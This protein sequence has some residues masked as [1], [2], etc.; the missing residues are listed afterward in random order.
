ML[1]HSFNDQFPG[2]PG[3]VIPE[4]QT[5]RIKLQ[6]EMMEVQ[7]WQPTD[8][9]GSTAPISSQII[10]TGISTLSFLQARCLLLPKQQRQS[11]EGDAKKNAMKLKIN[12]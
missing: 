3:Y 11:A 9:C 5:L 8:T 6:S 10:I 4:W 2:Q 7:W 1:V 12:N